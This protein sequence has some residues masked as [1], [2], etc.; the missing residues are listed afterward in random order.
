MCGVCVRGVRGVCVCASNAAY[1]VP[2]PTS[3][4]PSLPPS[5][6][7]SLPLISSLPSPSLL[8]P[9]LPLPSSPS[10]SSFSTPTPLETQMLDNMY[11]PAHT[12]TK[13]VRAGRGGREGAREE[14]GDP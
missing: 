14:G 8:L 6:S 3:C 4:S 7:L 11:T 1:R 5:L 13:G 2:R 9:L 10:P 12:V